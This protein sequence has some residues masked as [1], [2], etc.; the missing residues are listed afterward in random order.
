MKPKY[1]N[2]EW[3]SDGNLFHC[4]ASLVGSE[5]I[6]SVYNFM[7]CDVTMIVENSGKYV[8]FLYRVLV[9]STT[10]HNFLKLF[11]L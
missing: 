7:D 8:Q 1:T 3:I 4:G 5:R 11:F 9:R 6:E 10:I 2:T